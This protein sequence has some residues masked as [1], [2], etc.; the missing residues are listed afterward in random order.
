M[1]VEGSKS[2]GVRTLGQH[3]LSGWAVLRTGIPWNL[4]DTWGIGAFKVRARVLN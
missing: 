1:G 2:C 4:Q 3:S